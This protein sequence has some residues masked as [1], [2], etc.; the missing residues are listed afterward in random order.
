MQGPTRKGYKLRSSKHLRSLR[1]L[2]IREDSSQD[3]SSS[4][5]SS[6]PSSPPISLGV[7]AGLLAALYGVRRKVPRHPETPPPMYTA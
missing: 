4:T 6:A 5:T 1:A 3:V 2:V 7:A